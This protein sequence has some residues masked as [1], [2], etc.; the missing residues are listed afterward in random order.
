MIL[1]YLGGPRVTTRVL[2]RGGRRVR[3]KE[4]VWG[5]GGRGAEEERGYGFE[6]FAAGRASEDGGQDE[7]GSGFRKCFLA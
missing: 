6:G 2:I 1:D 4:P 7:E 3:V 5:G